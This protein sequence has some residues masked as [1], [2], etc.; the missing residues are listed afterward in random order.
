LQISPFTEEH[1][2]YI[3]IDCAVVSNSNKNMILTADVLSHMAQCEQG[4]SIFS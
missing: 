4:I 3:T 1:N 2:A